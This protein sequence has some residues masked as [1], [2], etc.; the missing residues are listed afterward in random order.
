MSSTA[1]YASGNAA[2]AQRRSSR[3]LVGAAAVSLTSESKIRSSQSLSSRPKPEDNMNLNQRVRYSDC[4]RQTC[5]WR[6]D[7]VSPTIAVYTD[8]QLAHPMPGTSAQGKF[9]HCPQDQLDPNM[10]GESVKNI[11]ERVRNGALSSH[12]AG[13][14][15]GLLQANVVIVPKAM[16]TRS[17]PIV[18]RT[19]CPAHLSM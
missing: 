17:T 3:S 14:C 12:T 10:T 4:Y 13:L 6:E 5:V 19:Q 18:G 11:R 15:P 7:L 2:I 16:L 8:H 9:E 1:T